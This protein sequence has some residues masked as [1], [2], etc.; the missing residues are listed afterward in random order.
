MNFPAINGLR[1]YRLPV[2][3]H[4]YVIGADPALG[5]PTS[6]DSALTVLHATTGEECAVLSGK[7]EPSVFAYHINEIGV[8]YND[9]AVM[10]ERNNMGAAVILWL[11]DNSKLPLL[12]G[13][14]DKV[15]WMSSTKGKALLY[16][17]CAD[18]FR[19]GTVILHSFDTYTQLASIEGATLCA[20]DGLHDDLA[21]SFALAACAVNQ[22]DDWYTP[23]MLRH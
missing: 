22:P 6:D 1:V 10:V 21:D 3:G 17:T 12:F 5:N 18:A 2:A 4:R 13:H 16:A 20:P 15:G 8:W 7:F 14:D 11:D 9:A 23:D 19:E